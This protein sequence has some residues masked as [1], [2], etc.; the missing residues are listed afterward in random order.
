M[1]AYYLEI[2]ILV[3]GFAMLGW[4]SF[5]SSRSRSGIANLGVAGLLIAFLFLFTVD[6]NKSYWNVYHFDNLAAFYKGIII[7]STLLVIVM[8][9]NFSP[10]LKRYTSDCNEESGIG[11]Y[12]CIP[13]FVCGF[14]PG[15]VEFVYSWQTT[16]R[17]EEMISTLEAI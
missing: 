8:G 17:A 5:S 15:I 10:V 12:Y 1:P 9:R 2:L 13:I 14:E 4:E 3:L 6:G 11:E 7:L 16:A